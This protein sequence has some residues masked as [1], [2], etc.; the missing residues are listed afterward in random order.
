V[1]ATGENWPDAL[2]GSALAGAVRGPILLTETSALPSAVKA[3]IKRLGAKDAYIVGGY[4]A[5]S[6][7]VESELEGALPGMVKRLAGADRYGTSKAVANE[8]ITI[9]G[10]YY[11]GTAIVATGM[12][13]PDAMAAAPLASGLG[14]PILLANPATGAVYVPAATDSA[15]IAGGAK[16][17]TSATES[18]LKTKL[19]AANVV[20]K[21]GS[22]RY[23]TAAMIA[24]HGAMS[25]L[26]WNGVGIATGQAFPDALA[27]GAALGQMQAVMLLTPTASLDPYAQAMLDDHKAHIDAIHF[28]G[29]TAAVSPAV[30]AE[31]KQVLGW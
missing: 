28:L 20:R 14:W 2:G 3:E 25:G 16:A 31:V 5:V 13:Y 9:L 1:I 26:M 11:D 6:A 8:V 18:G 7:A 24:E 21:G 30:E 23:Q 12:D 22:T 10:G 17:V 4:G 29:G 15:V 19:G 27:G